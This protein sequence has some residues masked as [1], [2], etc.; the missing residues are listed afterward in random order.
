M[1]HHLPP[2]AK[3]S[4]CW[5]LLEGAGLLEQGLLRVDL[6]RPST[7]TARALAAQWAHRAGLGS[8][9]EHA[10]ATVRRSEV[11]GRLLARTGTRGSFQ[12]QPK[13][14]LREVALVLQVWHFGDQRASRRGE[15]RARLTRV[16]RA[17]AQHL[18]DVTLRRRFTG[19]D[20]LQGLFGVR[21]V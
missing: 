13:V 16:V 3:L 10:T 6:Y 4:E 8:K 15:L 9:D 12:I 7:L 18:C 2:A 20:H 21:G 14:G 5:T 17:V 19:L 1:L 11:A